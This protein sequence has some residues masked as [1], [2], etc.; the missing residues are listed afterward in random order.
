MKMYLREIGY[1]DD[2]WIELAQDRVQWWS[3]VLPLVDWVPLRDCLLWVGGILIAH[4]NVNFLKL[5]L[6][7]LS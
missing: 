2:Q 6:N 5:K 7:E 3:M 1:E 4:R